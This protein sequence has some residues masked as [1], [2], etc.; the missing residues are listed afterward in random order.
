ME[1]LRKFSVVCAAKMLHASTV[2][3]ELQGLIL[4]RSSF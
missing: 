3:K 4:A 2:A 1:L